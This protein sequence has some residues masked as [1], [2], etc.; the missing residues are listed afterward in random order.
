MVLGGGNTYSIVLDGGGPYY[1]FSFQDS[2]QSSHA[3]YNWPDNTIFPYGLHL[4]KSRILSSPLGQPCLIEVLAPHNSLTEIKKSDSDV[5]L[6]AIILYIQVTILY[7]QVTI[8]YIQVTILYIQ[9]TILYIQVTILYI[10]VTILYIQVT[11]LYIQVTILYIQ[12]TI[13]YIQVTILYIQVTILYIQVTILY[14][15]VIKSKGVA[16]QRFRKFCNVQPSPK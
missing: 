7:I 15:Q 4:A 12:V 9:V 8:L 16:A 5:D 14:I 3:D 10:Q 13:L 11:I 2:P 6:Y 1:I